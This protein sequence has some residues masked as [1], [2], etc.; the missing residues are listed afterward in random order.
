[1]AGKRGQGA[2]PYKEQANGLWARNPL[3]LLPGNIVKI[4]LTLGK[5]ALID[6][7]D[8]WKIAELRW[9]AHRQHKPGAPNE[10]YY[11]FARRR[12]GDRA[13]IV[14]MH[15]LV[16]GYKHVDHKNHDGLDCRRENLRRADQHRN[17]AN[18]RRSEANT[19]GYKGVSWSKRDRKFRAYI[20]VNGQMQSLGYF[21]S[22]EEAARAYDEAARRHFGEF[23]HTNFKLH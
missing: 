21:D 16:A 3:T 7:V 8:L 23:A 17:G 2:Y 1:M 22:A 11:A 12:E 19:S 9:C 15:H 13:Y 4:G 6:L 20:K 5:V 14:K 10:L 18:Q